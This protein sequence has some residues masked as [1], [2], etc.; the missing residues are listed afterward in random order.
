MTR[1]YL[2]TAE[3]NVEPLNHAVRDIPPTACGCFSGSA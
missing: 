1:D 3:A 2:K